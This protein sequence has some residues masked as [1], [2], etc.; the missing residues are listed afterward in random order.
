MIKVEIT[1]SD[2]IRT[3]WEVVYR[4]IMGFSRSAIKIPY[5]TKTILLPIS[6]VEIYCEGFF[7]N[8]DTM[9]DENLRNLLSSSARNLFADMYA[10][11]IPEKKAERISTMVIFVIILQKFQ[12]QN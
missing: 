11:S 3:I 8:L 5:N 9:E 4:A 7:N 12:R 10:I 2:N 6:I 1:V